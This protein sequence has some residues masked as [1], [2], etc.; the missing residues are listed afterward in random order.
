MVPHLLTQQ[1]LLSSQVPG[2]SFLLMSLSARRKP[3][4]YRFQH[5]SF[6][7]AEL[8]DHHPGTDSREGMRTVSALVPININRCRGNGP[9][10]FHI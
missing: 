10:F 7:E 6:A 1:R 3:A 4:S 5:S 9:G 8:G 2:A